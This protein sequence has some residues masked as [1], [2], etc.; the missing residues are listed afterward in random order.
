MM[1]VNRRVVVTQIEMNAIVVGAVLV[2][3][4]VLGGD[5]AIQLLSS[6]PVSAPSVRW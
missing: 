1:I 4:D 5:S 6:M 3:M 2:P